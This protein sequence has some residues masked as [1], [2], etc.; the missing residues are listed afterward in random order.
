[1]Q[2]RNSCARNEHLLDSDAARPTDE[3]A[4]AGAAD[5]FFPGGCSLDRGGLATHAALDDVLL[6]AATAAAAAPEADLRLTHA[7]RHGRTRQGEASAAAH[8]S[9]T[10]MVL[11]PGDLAK[12][13]GRL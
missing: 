5:I 2:S 3:K 9:T 10:D 13:R 6:V 1:M 12:E 8:T 11:D 4:V 7:A